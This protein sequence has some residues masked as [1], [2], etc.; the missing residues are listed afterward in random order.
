MSQPPQRMVEDSTQIQHRHKPATG[1][2]PH[3]KD[4][5]VMR[6]DE[7][8][9]VGVKGKRNL[10]VVLKIGWEKLRRF[11]E[12][13]SIHG[14][15]ESDTSSS[16]WSV[17][18]REELLRDAEMQRAILRSESPEVDDAWCN[19]FTGGLR[20][21]SESDAA[22]CSDLVGAVPSMTQ[23]PET[24]V[25]RPTT[26]AHTSPEDH[27]SPEREHIVSNKV[28]DTT[29]TVLSSSTLL[30]Q[31]VENLEKVV[32]GNQSSGTYAYRPNTHDHTSLLP[33]HT[34]KYI[35]PYPTKPTSNPI[36]YTSPPPATSPKS[37]QPLQSVLH[38]LENA[39]QATIRARKKYDEVSAKG[40]L[41]L[42]RV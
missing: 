30:A 28:S 36:A 26:S 31:R 18:R 22:R 37:T 20:Q 19:L 34:S 14:D 42:Q 25:H 39:S 17:Q 32:Y 29:Q 35:S 24:S 27:S 33:S 1:D 21:S 41:E 10:L 4:R 13:D 40:M 11:D 3:R 2:D 7:G 15:D 5:A 9:V 38:E 6:G 12:R 23:S 16:D 8:R